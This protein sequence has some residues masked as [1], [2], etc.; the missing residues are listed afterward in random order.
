MSKSPEQKNQ[1]GSK[2][3]ELSQQLR[4]E[5]EMLYGLKNIEFLGQEDVVYTLYRSFLGI[6]TK[7]IFIGFSS[8][9]EIINY[10]MQSCFFG[11]SFNK[12]F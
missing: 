1:T 7:K 9:G 12:S 4:I 3:R 11:Y 6:F 2:E 8:Q 10:N 5:I